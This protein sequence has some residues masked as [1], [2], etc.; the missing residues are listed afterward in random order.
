MKR[1]SRVPRLVWRLAWLV[2]G[3]LVTHVVVAHAGDA[4]PRGAQ[5]IQQ[6]AQRV[7]TTGPQGFVVTL[8]AAKRLLLAKPSLARS[9]NPSPR[10]S[11]TR[12]RACAGSPPARSSLASFA[13]CSTTSST[14]GP[15]AQGRRGLRRGRRA[16]LWA[17]ARPEGPRDHLRQV[18][19]DEAQW[20]GHGAVREPLD[21]RR[22]RGPV[23]GGPARLPRR[24][25]P[26]QPAHRRLSQRP[27]WSR[28]GRT[29][30]GLSISFARAYRPLREELAFGAAA[31]SPA[32]ASV[33]SWSA[34][35][36]TLRRPRGSYHL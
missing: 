18:L 9:I 32:N 16:R 31:A 20:H 27:P 14:T 7:D 17:G 4:T 28:G 36:R 13:R 25:V 22:S 34:T 1:T 26:A 21:R 23:V 3:F 30:R 8:N 5:A 15:F 33:E 35:S 12:R 24:D 11:P 6:V 19:Y 10:S 29:R 2:V